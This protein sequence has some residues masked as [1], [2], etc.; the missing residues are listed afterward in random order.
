[1]PGSMVKTRVSSGAE[2]LPDVRILSAIFHPVILLAQDGMPVSF[3]K[4]KPVDSTH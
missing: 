1:M 2:P 3:I 4:G